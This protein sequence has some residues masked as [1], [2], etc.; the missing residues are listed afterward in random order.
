M[1]KMIS[2]TESIMRQKTL[3]LNSLAKE[4]QM[5]GGYNT[6]WEELS[7]FRHQLSQYIDSDKDGKPLDDIKPKTTILNNGH[8]IDHHA[9]GYFA[10]MNFDREG[11]SIK[12][13]DNSNALAPSEQ[14]KIFNEQLKQH[15][16]RLIY[17]PM[18][19]K[20]AIYPNIAVDADVI[21]NDGLVIPQWRNYIKQCALSG[22]EVV[23]CY[24]QFKESQNMLFSKNHH[25]SPAGAELVGK[26]VA[27]YIFKTTDIESK[28]EIFK[29]Q[30]SIIGSPV[31]LS[32]GNDNSRE[33]GMEYFKCML[34][35][36]DEKGMFVPFTGYNDSRIAI[37]GD[38]NNQCYRGSGCDVNSYI[39]AYLGYPVKYIG[40]Y[41]PFANRDTIDKLPPGSLA[42]KKILIYVGFASASFVRA[43]NDKICWGT[44]LIREDAFVHEE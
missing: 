17:V 29:K 13:D 24:N 31:T 40:R 30:N 3:L 6:R 5:L 42:G 16:I 1:D 36:M 12:Q 32:S 44:N 27:N 26:L 43:Y 37:I 10:P 33:L 15:G 19:C 34:V 20:V 25:L 35:G 39:S 28:P 22:I 18:P 9:V 38:C 21:P 8:V 41:L 2:N 4:E 14:M 7:Q 23:D 11:F